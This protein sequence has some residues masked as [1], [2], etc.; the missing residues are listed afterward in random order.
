MYS[1]TTLTLFALFW[2]SGVST[3]DCSTGMP[4]MTLVV[5]YTFMLLM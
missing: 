4:S 2:N 1:L 3:I 5:Q